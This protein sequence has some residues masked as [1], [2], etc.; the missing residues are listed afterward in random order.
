[1]YMNSP[2]PRLHDDDDGAE[3]L[4][5]STREDNSNRKGTF[6]KKIESKPRKAIV[7]RERFGL[8]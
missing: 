4:S 2:G 5:S 1:M 7:S 6:L 3:R 8:Y